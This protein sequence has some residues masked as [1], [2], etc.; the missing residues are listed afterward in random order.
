MLQSISPKALP[1]KVTISY[2][3]EPLGNLIYSGTSENITSMYMTGPENIIIIPSQIQEMKLTRLTIIPSA[4]ILLLSSTA[5][6]LTIFLY[7]KRVIKLYLS[8]IFYS[9]S[10]L[11]LF[12]QVLV[13]YLL[14]TQGKLKQIPCGV[15]KSLGLFTMILPS[16]AI[17][18]ITICRLIF[19]KYPFHY[20]NILRIKYQLFCCLCA[21]L[22]AF[23][24]SLW[25]AVGVCR[26]YFNED[27][28]MCQLQNNALCTTFVGLY[29]V[30]GILTPTVAVI[31]IYIYVY[32]V[33]RRNRARCSRRE[34]NSSRSLQKMSDTMKQGKQAADKFSTLP[35]ITITDCSTGVTIVNNLTVTFFDE[36]SHKNVSVRSETSVIFANETAEFGE[37]TKNVNKDDCYSFTKDISESKHDKCTEKDTVLI[38]LAVKCDDE[39]LSYNKMYLPRIVIQSPINLTEESTGPNPLNN[40]LSPNFLSPHYLHTRDIKKEHTKLHDMRYGLSPYLKEAARRLSSVTQYADLFIRK[41]IPWSLVLLTIIHIS[42]S[43][44]W[45]LVEFYNTHFFDASSDERVWMDF[46]NALLVGSVGVSPL[47]YIVFTRFIR[48]KILQVLCKGVQSLARHTNFF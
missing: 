46:G 36:K 41:E 26:P 8:L 6:C 9:I 19:I 24:M 29:I 38:D 30:L 28:K 39:T 45:I 32:N 7:F 5:L 15:T 2:G 20:R 35:S 11:I 4:V 21:I 25:P 23:G 14:A 3:L 34:S 37:P 43:V 48:D 18:L 17:L 47:L 22:V 42:S 40:S 13:F 10:E 12:L 44:P 33:L 16:L 31:G 27:H 1:K